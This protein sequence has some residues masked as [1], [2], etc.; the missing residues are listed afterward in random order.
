MTTSI[1]DQEREKILTQLDL[2]SRGLSEP[3]TLYSLGFTPKAS[4]TSDA[5]MKFVASTEDVDRAGDV[6]RQDGW[7]LDNFRKNS[8]FMWSHTYSIPPIGSIPRIWVEN[9]QLQH[10]VLFDQKDE[11]ARSVEN[12]YR[13]GFLSAVSVGFRPLEF[14]IADDG[15]GRVFTKTELLEVSAVGVP[16]NR[17][18][19]TFALSPPT[20]A[21]C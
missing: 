7:S 13:S 14:E 15:H 12:K 18:H 9:K 6:I 11:F 2:Y 16:M 19:C 3:P 4:Y 5:P 8:I 1:I 10:T 21:C 20:H 17:Q